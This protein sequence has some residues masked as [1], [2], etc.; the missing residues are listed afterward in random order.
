M[1]CLLHLFK[2]LIPNTMFYTLIVDEKFGGLFDVIC[3]C[4]CLCCPPVGSSSTKATYKTAMPV[5]LYFNK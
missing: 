5:C 2:D 4:L 1:A 3:V